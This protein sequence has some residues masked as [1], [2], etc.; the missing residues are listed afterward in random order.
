MSRV[1][2]LRGPQGTLFGSGSAS[3]TLRY[4]TNQ[5][6]MGVTRWFGEVGLNTITDGNQGGNAKLGV[7]H[8]PSA[9][10]RHCAWPGSGPGSAAGPTRSPPT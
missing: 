7:Q 2:V 5:P 10:R 1:E 8:A 3:G 6:E 4:I 9:T